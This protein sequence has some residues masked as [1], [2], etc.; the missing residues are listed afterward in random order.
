M[1]KTTSTL[2]I[3]TLLFCSCDRI[4]E[5]GKR[6][7]G[8]VVKELKEPVLI[9][10]Q[11]FILYPELRNEEF[12]VQHLNGLQAE[13]LPYFNEYYFKYTGNQ[14]KVLNFIC[15]LKV[16]SYTDIVPDT[17]L[18]GNSKVL[19]D[20]RGLSEK[21]LKKLDF[22]FAYERLDDYQIYQTIKTP[23]EHI[24]IIDQNSD[25][26]YHKIKEFRE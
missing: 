25:N 15:G 23:F 24:L 12:N 2:L 19:E 9:S 20:K 6:Y 21:M 1:H 3:L 17:C 14:E 10:R 26:I 5:R 18:L 8:A 13:Y 7:L 11:I 4:K 22:Y 16:D